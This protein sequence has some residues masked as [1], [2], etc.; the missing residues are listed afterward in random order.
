[1]KMVIQDVTD[2]ATSI[3]ETAP[4]TG[5]VACVVAGHRARATAQARKLRISPRLAKHGIPSVPVRRGHGTFDLGQISK[6]LPR[7]GVA[8]AG[9][10]GRSARPG[11][12][13][14]GRWSRTGQSQ[15]SSSTN[16]NSRSIKKVAALRSAMAEE[17]DLCAHFARTGLI[18]DASAVVERVQFAGSTC[19]VAP[20]LASLPLRP[21]AQL[22]F[23]LSLGKITYGSLVVASIGDTADRVVVIS[24]KPNLAQHQCEVTVKNLGS[25]SVVKPFMLRLTVFAMGASAPNS[26]R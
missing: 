14:F 9:A 18:S 23:L 1:M 25:T 3:T 15:L 2:T 7:R 24:T 26:W 13:G 11:R 12:A 21:F 20:S 16:R 4:R 5:D 19:H 6:A 22:R 17:Q 8:G 10:N